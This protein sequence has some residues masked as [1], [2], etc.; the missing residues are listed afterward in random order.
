MS[1]QAP[2]SHRPLFDEFKHPVGVVLEREDD[3]AEAAEKLVL[4]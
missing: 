2:R 1:C 4:P 3:G